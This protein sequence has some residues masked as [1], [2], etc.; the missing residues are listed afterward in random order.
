MLYPHLFEPINIG[1]LDVKNRINMP[2]MHTNLGNRQDGITEEGCDFYLARARGGFGMMGIGIIDAYFIEGAS[3]PL[4]F[5]LDNDRHIKNYA[6]LVKK[7]KSFGLWKIF[8]K[9]EEKSLEP[10][11]SSRSKA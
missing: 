6:R 3:S 10:G 11:M 7:I 8:R 1:G 5:F 9:S 4:E 2:P